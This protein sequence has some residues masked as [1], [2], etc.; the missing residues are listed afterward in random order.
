MDPRMF[1]K[2]L[3]EPGLSYEYDMDYA[4]NGGIFEVI[5]IGNDSIKVVSRNLFCGHWYF[6]KDMTEPYP[7]INISLPE[8]LFKL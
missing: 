8:D 6:D 2:S 1:V 4:E 3:Y 5:E 7:Q